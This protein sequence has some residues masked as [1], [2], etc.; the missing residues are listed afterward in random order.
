M[1][2]IRKSLAFSLADRYLQ[3]ALQLAAFFVLARLLTPAEIGLYSVAFAVISLA[4]VV[5]DLGI[6]TYLIQEKQLT[7]SCIRTAFTMTAAVSLGLFILI[8]AVAPMVASFYREPSLLAALRLLSV[9]FLIIPLSSVSLTLLHREMQFDVILRINTIATAASLGSALLLAYYGVGFMSLVWASLVQNATT[10]LAAAVIRP[11][12]I[13]YAPS[14]AEHR[15]GLSFGGRF[16]LASIINQISVSASDLM[17]GKLLDFAAVGL[18]SRAQGVM[19]IFHRDITGAVRNV[20]LPA[21]SQALRAGTAIEKQF[22]HSVT[23]FTSVAWPFY[24]FVCLFPEDSLSLLF[25]SQW[26]AAGPLV[27]WFCLGGAIAT[28]A[29]LVPTV[30]TA[31]GAMKTLLRIHFI[32]DPVRIALLFL[33]LYSFRSAL[34]FAVANCASML[35]SVFVLYFYKDR[36]QDTD[37]RQLFRG[38]AHSLSVTILALAAPLAVA[39]A[40]VGSD[41]IL[42]P[43]QLLLVGATVPPAW[44]AALFFTKHPLSSDQL[45]HSVLTGLRLRRS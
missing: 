45:F 43:W 31:H 30:L 3:T 11:R 28:I 15:R 2:G 13:L 1:I 44:L 23:I 22:V 35:L 32:V 38:L 40:T 12:E 41:K 16:T 33:A 29:S 26:L 39:V 18:I 10:C 34:V 25:G 42:E 24:G 4:H 17:A 14:L 21:F 27:F 8:N 37:Y 19:N 6:S 5:R 7:L 9:N 20:A 36:I